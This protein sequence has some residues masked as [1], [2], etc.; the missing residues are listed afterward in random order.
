MNSSTWQ[1]DWPLRVYERIGERGFNSLSE[2]IDSRPMVSL[3]GLAQELG[4]GIATVQLEALWIREAQE[5]DNLGHLLGSLLIRRLRH[6]IPDGWTTGDEFDFNLASGFATWGRAADA[7]LP[8]SEQTRL[9][10]YLR[11]LSPETGWLPTVPYDALTRGLMIELEQALART[12]RGKG[13][14]RSF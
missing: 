1:E 10:E 6:A 12:R 7:A 14:D 3:R 11:G 4:P 5:R 9:W 2:F 8:Q 13:T